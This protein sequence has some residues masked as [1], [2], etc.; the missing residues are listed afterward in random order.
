MRIKTEGHTLKLLLPKYI[1]TSYSTNNGTP[2]KVNI[3]KDFFSN[4][5]NQEI[6]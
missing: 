2:R 3:F 5:V 1:M 4:Q 6:P